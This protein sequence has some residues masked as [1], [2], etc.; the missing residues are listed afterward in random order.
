MLQKYFFL[1]H[2]PT[3]KT[4]AVL[5]LIIKWLNKSGPTATQT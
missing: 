4:N 5:D 2:P 1:K 3:T